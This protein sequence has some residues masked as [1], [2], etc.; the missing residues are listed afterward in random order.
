MFVI[1]T[2]PAACVYFKNMDL[3]QIFSSVAREKLVGARSPKKI[4]ST[5]NLHFLMYIAIHTS[6]IFRTSPPPLV[7]SLLLAKDLN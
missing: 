2:I 6:L 1:E 4:G 7:Y 5:E 3:L